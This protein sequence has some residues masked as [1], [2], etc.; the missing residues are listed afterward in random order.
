MC[1]IIVYAVAYAHQQGIAYIYPAEIIFAQLFTMASAVGFECIGSIPPAPVSF[2]FAATKRNSHFYFELNAAQSNFGI[3]LD[4]HLWPGIAYLPTQQTS[5]I[6]V[7]L[8]LS[9]CNI[10]RRG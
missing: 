3:T 9:I 7:H 5:P 6:T 1:E 4:L 10:N 8:E 2:P